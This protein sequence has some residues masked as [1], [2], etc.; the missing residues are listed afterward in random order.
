MQIIYRLFAYI[1]YISMYSLVM[2]DFNA[3]LQ[4]ER[5]IKVTDVVRGKY[6]LYYD[7]YP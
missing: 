5:F 2:G 4:G 6:L 7:V 3:H 1:H